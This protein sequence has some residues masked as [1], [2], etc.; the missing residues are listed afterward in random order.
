MVVRP[1]TGIDAGGGGGTIAARVVGSKPGETLLLSAGHVLVVAGAPVCCTAHDPLKPCGKVT[2]VSGTPLLDAGI[3][4][5]KAVEADNQVPPLGVG[6][7]SVARATRNA[8]V[9]K[10]GAASGVSVGLVAEEQVEVDIQYDTGLQSIRGFLIK[11]DPRFPAPDGLVAHGDSGAPWLLANGQGTA[12]PVLVGVNIGF[13]AAGGRW[14]TD[15]VLACHADEVMADLGVRLW[16]P[17]AQ[18][19]PVITPGAPPVGAPALP[20]PMRVAT[21]EAAIL[22]GLPS[23]TANRL[24]G[25]QPGQVVHVLGSRDGWA[26]VS[27]TGDRLIDGFVWEDLLRPAD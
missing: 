23:E 5:A 22:R 12:L 18:P 2:S 16:Q 13:P 3:A 15:W 7:A 9:I 17:G 6:I 1:G 27:L 24:G 26:T 11:P 4:L 25:L 10:A 8:Q 20:V 19:V 21:R 14:P